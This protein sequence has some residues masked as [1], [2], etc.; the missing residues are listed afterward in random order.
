MYTCDICT[1]IFTRKDNFIRHLRKFH[2]IGDSLKDLL[3]NLETMPPRKRT[4]DEVS[5]SEN[6]TMPPR[7]RTRD[8][9]SDSEN[10]EGSI[11]SVSSSEDEI[12]DQLNGEDILTPSMD[13]MKDVWEIINDYADRDYEGDVVR[14]YIDQVRIARRLKKNAVHKKVMETVAG[15]QERDYNMDF[16]EALLKAAN[17][18]KYIIEQAA[19]EAI[20][21]AEEEEAKE[22]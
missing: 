18:R 13:L 17:R 1:K 19:K 10:E 5:D 6:E 22:T 4:R 20:E 16:E 11:A 8:E 9:V 15:L 14:A 2:D 3:K 12:E 21:L 7:K